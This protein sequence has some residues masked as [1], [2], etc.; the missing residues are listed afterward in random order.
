MVKKNIKKTN[1]ELIDI[2]KKYPDR[3]SLRDSFPN[4]LKAIMS[5]GLQD[6]AFSHMKYLVRQSYTEKELFDLAAPFSSRK[7]FEKKQSSAYKTVCVRGLI[8]KVCAHMKRQHKSYTLELLQKL[9]APYK[10]RGDFAQKDPN[11]HRAAFRLGFLDIICSHMDTLHINHTFDSLSA[12]AKKYGSLAEFK[13]HNV[14]AYSAARI[15]GFL[16]QICVH[17][18]RSKSISGAEQEIR[19]I[20]KKTF[21]DCKTLRAT[22][23]KIEGKEFIKRLDIDI[24]IPSLRVGIEYDGT[25]FHSFAGL[26]RSRKH[27]PEEDIKNYHKIKDNYFLS[28]GI[29]IL[30]V[31]EEDWIS[32][33]STSI[34][35]IVEFIKKYEL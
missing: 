15:K 6:T 1:Q 26:Q 12:E 22:N 25:Y 27:W 10:T 28:I 23:L 24:Y 11:A 17:M 30:H 5:R 13:F 21:M 20:V 35:T 14:N 19:D 2:A 3:Q 33:K 9:A 16:D 7:E 8:D 4:I 29:P 32:D 31:K 34:R 18:K